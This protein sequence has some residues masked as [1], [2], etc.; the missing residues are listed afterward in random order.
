MVFILS[1]AFAQHQR[2]ISTYVFAQYS[3]TMYDI[4]LG[5]NPSGVG[6]GVQT[7]LNNKTK[8]KPTI[9]VTSKVYLENDKVLRI[10][11]A[12]KPIADVRGMTNVFIGSSFQPAENMYVS[13]LGGTSF[14]NGQTFLGIKPSV[15]FYFSKNQKLSGKV[16]F[17]N[18]FNRDKTT[19]NDFGSLVFALGLKLF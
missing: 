7:F 15:G 10:T 9:E 3:K 1:Q 14:I 5:N 16:S 4:T 17:V 2:K 18:I 13:F 8:F 12:D 11:S 19:K 6:I